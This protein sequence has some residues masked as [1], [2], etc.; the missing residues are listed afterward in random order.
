MERISGS[1]CEDEEESF[2]RLCEFDDERTMISGGEEALRRYY[3][4]LLSDRQRNSKRLK[5][6]HD[7]EVQIMPQQPGNGGFW[8]LTSQQ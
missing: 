3:R 8:E 4:Q 2:K 6:D 1:T 7:A 5:I